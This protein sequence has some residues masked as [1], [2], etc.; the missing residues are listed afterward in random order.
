LGGGLFP[1]AITVVTQGL[2]PVL[3]VALVLG[4][5]E[6]G[7]GGLG[8]DEVGVPVLVLG[9][10]E[11]GILGLGHD[12]VGVPLVPDQ[13]EVVVILGGGAQ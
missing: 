3:H 6:V 10:A 5:A 2:P 13:A 4:Q 8:Q 1:V 9:Q 11:V 12:E 7:M